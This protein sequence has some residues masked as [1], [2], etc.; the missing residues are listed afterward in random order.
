MAIKIIIILFVN[1]YYI[2]ENTSSTEALS[3]SFESLLP[4][5][6]VYARYPGTGFS[7]SGEGIIS[8]NFY[9]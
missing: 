8:K 1:N 5:S 6:K 2:T 7:S 3:K 4:G 9:K